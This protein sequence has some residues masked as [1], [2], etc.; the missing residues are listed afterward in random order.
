MSPESSPPSSIAIFPY[1]TLPTLSRGANDNCFRAVSSPRNALGFR[2]RRCRFA[3]E[4]AVLGDLDGAAVH[5]S[6]HAT[7]DHQRVA[8]GDLGA[9]Q[10][11]SGDYELAHG[12]TA[13]PGRLRTAAQLGFRRFDPE[14][15]RFS[16]RRP[17]R[18]RLPAAAVRRLQ[19]RGLREISPAKIVQHECSF[20]ISRP[21]TDHSRA[22]ICDPKCIAVA[23]RMP[24]STHV[25]NHAIA[26]HARTTA[27]RLSSPSS[28]AASSEIL[29][30]LFTMEVTRRAK[31]TRKT[32]TVKTEVWERRVVDCEI[33]PDELQHEFVDRHLGRKTIESRG[34]S[35][36]RRKSP[37][38]ASLNPAASISRRN[39]ASSMRCRDF[40]TL[41]PAPA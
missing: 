24:D 30:R 23:M 6:L 8:V 27:K 20:S 32:P 7:L 39:V 34:S 16:G 33:R 38:A 18:S 12:F 31:A 40:A 41:M 25:Q 4:N 2:R 19:A 14:G 37:S 13:G 9:L 11:M 17:P 10:F 28:D 1:R 36:W 15:F 26:A 22:K 21:A 29:K 5:R 35:R 3:H